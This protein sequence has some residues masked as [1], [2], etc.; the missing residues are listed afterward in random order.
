MAFNSQTPSDNVSPIRPNSV[1]KAKRNHDSDLYY[2]DSYAAE[3][4]INVHTSDS[5]TD[6]FSVLN[7]P[8][9]TG[10]KLFF[11]FD[12]TSGLLA[13]EQHQNSALAY[14][15][16]IGQ[17]ER[18]NLLNRFINVLSRVNSET[19]WI[20]QSIDG[21][22]ELWNVPFTESYVN[23]QLTLNTLETI[24]G[25]IS[26][27]ATMYRN[28]AYDFERHV[29]VLPVN[30]RRFSMSIYLYD[31]RNFDN[32]SQ[33][34][35]DLLQTVKNQDVNDL[36]H[37]LLDVGY[38]QFDVTSGSGPASVASNISYDMTP[39]NLKIN[40]EKFVISALFKSITGN[41][42]VSAESFAF[43]DAAVTG[44][45]EF[46]PDKGSKNGTFGQVKDSVNELL[47]LD[48]WKT[49]A[50]NIIDDQQDAFIDRVRATVVAKLLG[51]VHGF[52]LTDMMKYST[53]SDYRQQFSNI[54]SRIS[55][56]ASL[57]NQTSVDAEDLGNIYE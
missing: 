32:L 34:A 55:G 15:K 46:S 5:D 49:K 8:T 21:L 35:V 23:K 38:C 20:F 14:L 33:T 44:E 37:T 1:Q 56:N 6:A 22:E 12:A 36:N 31:F 42:K 29:E 53:D 13:N 27:L 17:T 10:F 30:L 24:D 16:R 47:N 43:T 45:S 52:A 54:Y 11:H 7:D 26:S 18:Y 19:P 2:N 50:V 25:K 3:K 51:N 28:I 57:S 4:F 48:S 40:Y 9:Y 41:T 39:N